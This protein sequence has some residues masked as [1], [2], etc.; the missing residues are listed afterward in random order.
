MLLLDRGA[1]SGN[2]I[3][4]AFSL[5]Q[6]CPLVNPIDHRYQR[7][8]VVLCKSYAKK[9]YQPDSSF[10]CLGPKQRIRCTRLVESP[11][12]WIYPRVS[13]N[14]FKR[15]RAFI[16]SISVTQR[17][18]FPCYWPPTLGCFTLFLEFPPHPRETGSTNMCKDP[19]M[20]SQH[21]QFHKKRGIQ[22][23]AVSKTKKGAPLPK[24]ETYY[25]RK[26][27]CV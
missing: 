9:R 26:L 10:C 1:W 17:P 20:T 4:G 22:Q 24:L 8:A 14:I 27:N 16:S 5:A 6:I 15:P 13:C 12:P 25:V 19:W 7:G 2:R 23:I 18:L 3:W 21:I 11:H